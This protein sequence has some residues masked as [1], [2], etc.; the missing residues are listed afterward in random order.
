MDIVFWQ[1]MFTPHMMGLAEALADRG[2]NV[3]FIAV[4]ELSDERR[5]QGW[6]VTA[7]CKVKR[8]IIAQP[9]QA[10]EFITGLTTETIHIAQGLRGNAE[11]GAYQT[12]ISAAGQRLW[13]ILESIDSGGWRS[14]FRKAL[15]RVEALRRRHKIEGLLAIG[16]GTAEWLS[17][18]GFARARVFPFTYFISQPPMTRIDETTRQSLPFT[19]GFV[20][21]LEPW[22]N[23]KLALEAFLALKTGPQKLVV[24]GDGS[25]RS[26][27]E[28]IA[29]S[30]RPEAQI[31]FLGRLPM[32]EVPAQLAAL[33]ALILPSNIDGWGVVA[34]EAMLLGTPVIVSDACGVRRAVGVAPIGCVFPA[35]DAVQLRAAMMKVQGLG[36]DANNR[37]NLQAWAETL[38]APFGAKYLE[39]ILSGRSAPQVPEWLADNGFSV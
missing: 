20:G 37:A 12:L 9:Q 25:L 32:T 39:E 33:D 18:R 34:S 3:F 16:D 8:H 36:R 7:A 10:Q 38:S 27:L 2:H 22:K 35:G 21:N 6:Q 14:F 11:I 17:A 28:T 23:P 30:T 31:T 5:R 15:Y 4:E 1:R 26:E 29:S 24:V 19:F 13:V